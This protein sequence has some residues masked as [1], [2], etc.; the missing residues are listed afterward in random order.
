MHTVQMSANISNTTLLKDRT[1]PAPAL[2]QEAAL[3]SLIAAKL[4]TGI[5]A[6]GLKGHFVV[7]IH[8]G[9]GQAVLSNAHDQVRSFA[10]L[11]TL[12]GLLSRLGC[13]QFQV[14][15]TRFEPGRIRPAQPE[16]SAAMK[17]GKLPAKKSAMPTTS[18]KPG[19][20]K[21]EQ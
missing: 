10:S 3:R 21:N 5:T 8:F 6:V 14:N 1:K 2:L 4:I 13:Q 20:K 15:T 12:A 16:R 7:E 18:K 19:I 17:A 11:S 9:D